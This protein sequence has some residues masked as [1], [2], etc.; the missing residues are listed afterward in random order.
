MSNNG[1]LVVIDGIDGSGKTTQVDLL[2]KYLKENNISFE[3]I[4]FPRYESFYGQLIKRYLEGEFGSMKAANPHLIALA[5]ASDRLLAKPQIE[6][7]LNEGKLVIA[8][9]Y[10]SASKAH[11]GAIM[12]EDQREEFMSWVEELEYQINNL[13]RPDLNILLLVDPKVGQENALKDDLVDMHEESIEH[14]E[15]ASKIF[16]EISQA[17]ENWQV[18]DCMDNIKMKPEQK[19]HQEVIEILKKHGIINT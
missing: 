9:R 17:E 11:L 1:F 5:Y 3:V 7:W 2:S 13:P 19:I 6:Q 12:E 18:L 4:S 10:V 8:N 14:E 15:K 16:F